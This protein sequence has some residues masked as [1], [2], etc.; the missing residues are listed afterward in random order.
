M[1]HKVEEVSKASQDFLFLDSFV[2]KTGISKG[3]INWIIFNRHSNGAD[4]F[5]RRLGRKRWM[6]SLTLF[7]QWLQ[8][9]DKDEKK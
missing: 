2:E 6:V 7:Y 5:L 9:G 8:Q 4:F 1:T 3:Q